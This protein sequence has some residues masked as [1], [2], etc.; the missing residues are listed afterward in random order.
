M[1]GQYPDRTAV[2]CGLGVSK[3]LDW[4]QTYLQYTDIASLQKKKKQ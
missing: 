2:S 4:A 1:N 3:G